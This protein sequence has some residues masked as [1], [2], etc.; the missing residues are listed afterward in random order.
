MT[1][2]N[3]RLKRCLFLTGAFSVISAIGSIWN[4]THARSFYLIRPPLS[5]M[6]AKWKLTPIGRDPRYFT[7][8]EAADHVKISESNMR[9]LIL[10][11]RIKP[12]PI[13]YSWEQDDFIVDKGFT[14]TPLP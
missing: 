1:L 12:L 7:V 3:D 14:V 2:E 4:A 5:E 10:M 6:E 11:G 8:K 13:E 9:A